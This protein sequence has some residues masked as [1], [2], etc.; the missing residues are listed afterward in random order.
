MTEQAATTKRGAPGTPLSMEKPATRPCGEGGDEGVHSVESGGED[1]DTLES[2][3]YFGFLANFKEWGSPSLMEEEQTSEFPP[4]RPCG[5]GGGEGDLPVESGGQDDGSLESG[6]Y[7]G[8]LAKKSFD[9]VGSLDDEDAAATR[10][11]NEDRAAA[12]SLEKISKKL[13]F[14]EELEAP[15]LKEGTAVK[16][17]NVLSGG[18]TERPSTTASTDVDDAYQVRVAHVDARLRGAAKAV[19]AADAAVAAVVALRDAGGPLPTRRCSKC[20]EIHPFG[21]FAKPPITLILSKMVLYYQADQDTAWRTMDVSSLAFT[22][23]NS[24]RKKKVPALTFEELTEPALKA[25]TKEATKVREASA[26]ALRK[27]KAFEVPFFIGACSNGQCGC[28]GGVH[29]ACCS[30]D[31]NGALFHPGHFAPD[32][33]DMH[34]RY[35]AVLRSI[36]DAQI[37]LDRAKG[38]KDIDVAKQKL[39]GAAEEMGSLWCRRK[40]C[41]GCRDEKPYNL[42]RLGRKH[43]DL[44]ALYANFPGSWSRDDAGNC[45]DCCCCD[46]PTC[47]VCHME[48]WSPSSS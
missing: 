7:F 19:A 38:Q 40:T 27:D 28:A 47:S 39:Y 30:N 14:D 46:N 18:T 8:V 9:E 20:G 17:G 12:R 13:D 31:C 22:S 10:P 32:D 25:A 45:L 15:A 29:F 41:A 36:D 42:T 26:K 16:S 6:C 34:K 2:G 35:R 48:G 21:H 33:P 23:C 3:Q 44:N 11:M 24:C 37:E 4:T 1:D 43:L 5:E